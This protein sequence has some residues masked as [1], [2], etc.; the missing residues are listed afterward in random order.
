[1]NNRPVLIDINPFHLFLPALVS[2]LHRISGIL[3]FF[4]IPLMLWLLQQSLQSEQ[5]FAALQAFFNQVWIKIIFGLCILAF[6]FHLFAGIRH[7]LMDI[8][9]ADSKRGGRVGAGMVLALFLLSIIVVTVAI[10]WGR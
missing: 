8:H 10:V 5:Q 7:L 9:I 4:L 1:M 3:I 2:I 6:C